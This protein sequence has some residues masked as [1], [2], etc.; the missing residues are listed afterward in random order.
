[1]LEQA[2]PKEQCCHLQQFNHAPLQQ[3][4][5]NSCPSLA[6]ASPDAVGD[7]RTEQYRQCP[8]QHLPP[9]EREDKIPVFKISFLTQ[10]HPF[11]DG[12]CLKAAEVIPA[13]M[14]GLKAG[15][16]LQ[17]STKSPQIHPEGR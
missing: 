12:P 7:P 11:E 9:S 15:L 5:I 8:A 2:W 14:D 4:L 3:S 16:I 13:H 17:K 10:M 6:L 1:M